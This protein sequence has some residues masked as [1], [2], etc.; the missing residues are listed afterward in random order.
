MSAREGLDDRAGLPP[1]SQLPACAARRL[2]HS[3]PHRPAACSH[4]LPRLHPSSLH[5][6]PPRRSYYNLSKF[7]E[8]FERAYVMQAREEVRWAARQKEMLDNER[9]LMAHKPGWVVNK[10]RYF[11]QWEDRPDRDVLDLRKP[12]IW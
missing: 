2:Q 11:T 12:G 8:R 6:P 10:R 4:P 7:N 3:H 9:E 5:P 1:V